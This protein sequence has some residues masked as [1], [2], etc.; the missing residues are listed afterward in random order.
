MGATAEKVGSIAELEEAMK[1][2]RA[3]DTSYVILIDTDPMPTSEEGGHWWDVVV[4]EVSERAEVR[5][6]RAD[7]EAKRELRRID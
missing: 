5:A 2:A 3:S 6:A 1:R 7:Y 4:P